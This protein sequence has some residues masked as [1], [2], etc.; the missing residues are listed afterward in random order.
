MKFNLD[1][2]LIF[3]HYSTFSAGSTIANVCS[4]WMHYFHINLARCTCRPHNCAL[5]PLY[6]LVFIQIVLPQNCI[7]CRCMPAALP[8]PLPFRSIMINVQGIKWG[9]MAG[10]GLGTRPNRAIRKRR[11]HGKAR[12]LQ[13]V[14]LPG[15]TP[16]PARGW[17]W[18]EGDW[19][20]AL[21]RWHYELAP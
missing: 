16:A 17:D 12:H 6:N 13:T 19:R 2:S 9:W 5:M 3:S 18:R 21:C 8:L 4:T 11:Q 7:R 1:L 15:P 10:H 20:L 14:W